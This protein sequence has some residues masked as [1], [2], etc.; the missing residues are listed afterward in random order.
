MDGH[1]QEV[2]KDEWGRTTTNMRKRVEQKETSIEPVGS[3]IRIREMDTKHGRKL[4][5]TRT[6]T[7][8]L[9]VKLVAE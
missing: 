2:V 6:E 4:T 1:E 7:A 5:A 9:G 8:G 3:P